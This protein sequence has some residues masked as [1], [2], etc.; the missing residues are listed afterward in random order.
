[1]S[2]LEFNYDADGN[3]VHITA[4]NT[5]LSVKQS[6][7]SVRRADIMV[8]GY[9]FDV[10]GRGNIQL[11]PLVRSSTTGDESSFLRVL[12]NQFPSESPVTFRDPFPSYLT[13]TLIHSF[14][15]SWS[16]LD[17]DFGIT[18]DHLFFCWYQTFGDGNTRF[19]RIS[20]IDG[21]EDA[22]IIASNF[23]LDFAVILSNETVYAFGHE[24]GAFDDSILIKLNFCDETYEAVVSESGDII[25][26]G[27]SYSRL[28]HLFAVHHSYNDYNYIV[29]GVMFYTA[30][31][32][33]L[34]QVT[35]YDLDTGTVSDV[36]YAEVTSSPILWY[37]SNVNISKDWIVTNFV[38]NFGSLT[39]SV[40]VCPYPMAVINSAD[41]TVL[42]SD[43]IVE[44]VDGSTPGMYNTQPVIDRTTDIAY[45]F[46]ADENTTGP[47]YLKYVT[48][49]DGIMYSTAVSSFYLPRVRQ[50]DQKAYAFIWK[51]RTE[52][53]VDYY[54][55]YR[56]PDWVPLGLG[57]PKSLH[58]GSATPVFWGSIDEV[59]SRFWVAQ[60]SSLLGVSLEEGNEESVSIPINWPG[61]NIPFSYWFTRYVGTS[62][63]CGKAIMHVMSE[64]DSGAYQTDFYLLTPPSDCGD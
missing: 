61:G 21:Q 55:L 15:T 34:I 5:M 4:K 51:L 9:K 3:K 26:N 58:T 47:F 53:G 17:T 12:V 44:T 43:N 39:S 50:G 30:S 49:S 14:N 38:S 24:P 22:S 6:T 52:A 13:P 40:N 32:E 27:K 11:M 64:N 23:A 7:K 42:I 62:I 63:I 31:Y 16:G 1:M 60:A 48:L 59:N 36:Q 46:H 56:L 2:L 37:S 20:F 29:F 10:S 41:K 8:K 45:F 35:W 54:Q 28:S 25:Y 18:Y 33:T 19:S 57:F